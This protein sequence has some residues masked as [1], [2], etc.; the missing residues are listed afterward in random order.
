VDNSFDSRRCES[1]KDFCSRAGETSLIF[2]L[3]SFVDTTTTTLLS[4]GADASGV[5]ENAGLLGPMILA[6]DPAEIFV[7]F[8]VS[9]NACELDEGWERCGAGRY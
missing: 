6:I 8:G 7:T 1:F 4:R 3:D 2:S 5:D 9:K